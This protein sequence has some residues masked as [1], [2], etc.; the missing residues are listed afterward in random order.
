MKWTDVPA[1]V[2]LAAADICDGH[3]IFKPEAFLDAGVPQELVD[4]CTNVHESDFSNPKYTISG[5]DGKPVNQM[6]GIYGLDA[7]ATMI[8]D[9]DL[10]AP[11]RSGRGFQAQVW[12]EALHKHLAPADK[13]VEA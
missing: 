3:T 2:V 6:A 11:Q 5:P 7:L 12:K 1:E 13:K 8:R 9:F 4:R 10:D